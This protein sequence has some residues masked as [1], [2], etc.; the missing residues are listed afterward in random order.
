MKI[1]HSTAMHQMRYGLGAIVALIILTPSL[2]WGDVELNF[3]VYTSDK[4]SVMVLKFRPVLNALTKSLEEKL[5]QPVKIRLQV[6]SGYAKGVEDLANGRVD[7]SRFGPASYIRAKKLNPGVQILAIESK[8]GQK[9]FNGVICVRTDSAIQSISDLKGK[10]FAF[11]NRQS[12]I[13]RYLSQNYLYERGIRAKDLGAFDYLGRHDKVGAAVASGKYDAGALKESTFKKLVKKGAPL[14]SIASFPNVTK[15]WIARKG[16][17]ENIFVALR[18]SLLSLDD[19]AALKALKKNGFLAGNDGDY[20]VI[21]K[22]I[23]KNSL[24]FK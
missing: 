10:R 7:F 1:F 6:S 24:F 12:T 2:V 17:P 3:G 23:N 11:G 16:L 13:G 22:A 18:E 8:S 19:P 20:T 5:G 4:P 21:R 14:R 9:I 15:P